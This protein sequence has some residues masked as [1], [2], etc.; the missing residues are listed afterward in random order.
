[1]PI[2][3]ATIS[4]QPSVT[5]TGNF[6]YVLYEDMNKSGFQNLGAGDNHF[7][8][9]YYFAQS[10]NGG[11][12]NDFISTGI[13]WDTIYGGSG[14]DVIIGN[15]GND[16]LYGGSGQDRI[17][18]G[19]DTDT[20]DGGSGNDFLYGDGGNDVVLG[21]AGDDLIFGDNFLSYDVNGGV[22]V[23][24]GGAG[25]DTIYG[26]AGGD[27]LSG[28][29][30]ADHFVYSRV[31]DSTLWNRDQIRDFNHA[32]GDRI[33]LSH[34]AISNGSDQFAFRNSSA[35]GSVWLGAVGHDA[36]GNATQSVFINVDGYIA[37][38]QIDVM[39]APGTASLSAADF[40]L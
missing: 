36:A 38:M 11:A 27:V 30:G 1:M 34:L 13:G 33:D 4:A 31:A 14:D 16:S 7:D 15:A 3:F 28:G 24:S 32:E 29:T 20:I 10:V 21:G 23:L 37:D 19:A 25:N 9:K 17:F 26:D 5:L 39:L 8:Y 6:S 40:I 12:G 22:D 35:P 18:G 2:D